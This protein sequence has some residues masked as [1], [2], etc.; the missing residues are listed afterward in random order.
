MLHIQ[1]ESVD[2]RAVITVAADTVRPAADAK[3]IE[4]LLPA[5]LHTAVLVRGDVD[6][7]RQVISNLLENAIKF[8]PSGGRV[9]VTLRS[10][11]RAAE[12]V[13]TDTGEGITPEFLPH[14][15]ERFRQADNT[16]TMT[17]GLGLGL[18]IVQRLVQAHGGCV[19]AASQGEGRGATFVVRLPSSS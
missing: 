14:V 12:I 6:R 18:A 13:V 2:L 19:Y 15:F 4:L 7:L 17:G 9:S 8:T 16:N 1:K 3:R 5:D 10:A 11:N